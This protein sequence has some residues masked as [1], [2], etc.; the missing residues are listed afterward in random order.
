[1][2]MRL[3]VVRRAARAARAG[4]AHLEMTPTDFE[5]HSGAAPLP[6]DTS[7]TGL[8]HGIVDGQ[9]E[10]ANL[11]PQRDALHR[12]LQTMLVVCECS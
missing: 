8:L 7:I 1:M 5:R 2:R 9:L 4:V 12:M 11:G 3:Q 10:G 6:C